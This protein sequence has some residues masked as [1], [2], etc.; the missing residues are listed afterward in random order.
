[1]ITLKTITCRS[2]SG[3]EAVFTYDH[4]YHEYFLVSCDGLYSVKNAISTSQNATT[5]GTTYN[6]EGLEQRNIVITANIIRN[7][8]FNREFLSK[9]FKVHSEGTF[10]HE[11][12][13]D[14]REINYRVE[15][16]SVEEKGIIRSAQ[17]SL[18]CTD[19]YFTSDGE[20]TIE[21][22]QWYDDFEFECEIPEEGMEFGHRE[23]STIKQV[24]NES[25]K[26]VGITLT[27]EADDT[28]VNPIIYNQ[29]TNE[30]L[31][32]L[33]TMQANDKIVI[34]TIEGNITVELIRNGTTIDYNYTVDEDNDGYIQLAMGTN[35]I[36]YDADDGVEYLNV[37]FEYKNQFMFA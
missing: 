25:T 23:T 24:D 16:I 6:G 13:G 1:M 31:K 34:K 35:V 20:I 27:L 3:L 10:I 33:C 11:E 2:N 5:D 19:P 28:V 18:I 4:D 12:E 17:I 37:K 8:R 22:S 30:T 15:S 36:K 26:D 9:V 32:L 7:H 14:R 21:M 29:T